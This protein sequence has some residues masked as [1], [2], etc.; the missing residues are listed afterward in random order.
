MKFLLEDKV[1]RAEL[2]C[3]DELDSINRTGGRR[4]PLVFMFMGEYT[5]ELDMQLKEYILPEIRAG[6]V[7]PFV[8][9]S[10]GPVEWDRDYSPWYAMGSRGR[11]FEGR[12]PQYRR[13]IEQMLIPYLQ[14]AYPLSG[15]VYTI[16]Y[17]L[18]GLAALYYYFELGFLGCVSC[19]ASLW[20]PGWKAYLAEQL[21][22][23]SK[24]CFSLKKYK[25]IE[26]I[27]VWEVRRKIQRTF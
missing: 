22:S 14:E 27:S 25:R 23:R 18:G 16:G 17:S 24:E 1:C 15:K 11:I 3:A 21:K 9:A 2:F 13:F 6:K 7:E 10:F 26:F 4:L 20:Y 19:S 5:E 12:A 8:L